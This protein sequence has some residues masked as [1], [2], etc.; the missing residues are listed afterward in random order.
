MGL[1]DNIVKIYMDQPPTA[2]KLMKH[3]R[4][5]REAE[6]QKYVVNGLILFPPLE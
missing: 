6:Q 2:F 4:A 3:L 5:M 1:S